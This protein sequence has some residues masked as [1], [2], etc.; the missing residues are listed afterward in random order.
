MVE[1]SFLFLAEILRVLENF[2]FLDAANKIV[3]IV[4]CSDCWKNEYL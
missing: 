3:A 2:V 4:V 1:A